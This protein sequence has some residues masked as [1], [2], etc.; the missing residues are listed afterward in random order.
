VTLWLPFAAEI[1]SCSE[2]GARERPV[3]LAGSTTGWSKTFVQGVWEV[4]VSGRVGGR[5]NQ[6]LAPPV[7]PDC[8]DTG[9]VVRDVVPSLGYVVTL[10][11][12]SRPRG[13]QKSEGQTGVRR[14]SPQ[15]F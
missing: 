2:R 1:N 6:W 12:F 10:V 5:K 9:Q 3:P 15:I 11:V 7:C 8:E 4:T 13:F 14:D